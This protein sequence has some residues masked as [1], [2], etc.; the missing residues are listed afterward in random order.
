MQLADAKLESFPQNPG[1]YRFLGKDKKILYIGKATNLRQRVRSYFDIDLIKTRG[2]FIVDMVASSVSI[3]YEECPTVLDA[4]VREAALIKKY[5]PT[6]NTREKDNR[7]FAYIVITKEDYPRV[8]QLRE[9]SIA[10]DNSEELNYLYTFGP[11]QSAKLAKNLLSII[12]RIIP[13]RDKCT[14]NSGKPCFHKELGLCPGVCDGSISH[15]DYLKQINNLKLLL[16]GNHEKLVSKWTIKMNKAAKD[17]EFEE[18]NKYKNLIFAL[19]HINDVTLISDET[20]IASQRSSSLRDREFRVEGYDISHL[21]GTY[22]VG[23]MVVVNNG[24]P[25]KSEYR[26][27]KIREFDDKIDDL[28]RIREI[29]KRRFNHNEW[30]RPDIIVIDGGNTHLRFVKNVLKN[31]NINIPVVSVVKDQRHKAKEILG[32]KEYTESYKNSILIAN[33]ESHRFA[34]EYHRFLRERIKNNVLK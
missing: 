34:V 2:R 17:L 31:L 24:R 10:M 8:I 3:I 23:V 25:N 22:T 4:L 14:P 1:V 30:Q 12:R 21:S 33:M 16:E 9:R 27:F 20:R 5:K 11:F 13:F 18:A 28:L 19:T 15:G 7:S 32:P 26:K 6:Y 29:L